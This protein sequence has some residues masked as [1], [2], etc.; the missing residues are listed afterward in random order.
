MNRFNLT[1][2]KRFWAIAKLYW[3]GNEKKGANALLVLLGVL[4]LANSTLR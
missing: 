3:L 1:V 4:L 2:V